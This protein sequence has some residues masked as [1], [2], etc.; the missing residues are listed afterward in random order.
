MNLFKWMGK[1]IMFLLVLYVLS[2]ILVFIKY[3]YTA[4]SQR[5]VNK[6]CLLVFF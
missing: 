5:G 4:L 2:T 1:N 6:S 3:I